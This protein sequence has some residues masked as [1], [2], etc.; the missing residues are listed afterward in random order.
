MENFNLLIK[1]TEKT[2]DKNIIAIILFGSGTNQDY[3]IGISDYDFIFIFSKINFEVIQKIEKIE[4]KFSD[5]FKCRVDIKPFLESEYLGAIKGINSF[6]FFNG[7]ALKM[8]E[9]GEQ[10]LLFSKPTFNIP[11]NISAKRVK[12]D[13]LD[14]ASFYMTK[15]RKLMFLRKTMI[16]D[17]EVRVLSNK[18]MSKI[19]VSC[20]KNI[21]SFCLAHKGIV[22]SDVEQTIKNSEKIFGNMDALK[23]AYKYK[24]KGKISLK[25]LED[26]YNISEKVYEKTISVY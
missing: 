23:R 6:S 20:C 3:L 10:K 18:D 9:K 13:A 26:I 14:R 16:L 21:L 5:K 19:C 11:K 22:T 17:G 25:N 4:N 1:Y 2:F 12:K 15:F 7:W 8:I 24:A